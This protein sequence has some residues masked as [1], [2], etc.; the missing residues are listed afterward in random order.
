MAVQQQLARSAA[1]LPEDRRMQFRIGVHLGDV[2]E[3]ADGTVYGDG[4]NIAARLQSLAE[5]GGIAVSESIRVA[6]KGKVGAAFEDQGE[7]RVKN[8]ADPV[9]TFR[10]TMTSSEQA[11][12]PKHPSLCRCNRPISADKPSIAVL[13]FANMSGDPEQE[14]FTDGITEDIITELSRFDS[15]FVIA[16][17]SS[18]TYKGKAVDVKQVGRELGVRYVVE[19]SIRRIGQPHSGHGPIDRYALRESHLGRAL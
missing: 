11:T 10:L 18:F 14:Y 4:V 1:D 12:A 7:Q 17:N 6:V 13:A 3:K 19:G 9:R 8:I 16:R 15:L 5:P 2:I